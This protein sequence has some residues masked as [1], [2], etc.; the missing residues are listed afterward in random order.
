[1]INLLADERK[2]D[3]RA[4]RVNVILSRYIAI[5]LMALVFMMAV[6]FVS[7]TVLQNTMST[8]Q[9]RIDSND[10][11]AD[12]YSNTKAQVDTLSSKLADTKSTLEQEISYSKVLTTL[13]QVMPEGTVIGSFELNEASFTGSQMELKTYAKTNEGAVVIAEKLRASPLITQVSLQSTDTAQGIEGYPIGVNLTIT[14]NR[15]WAK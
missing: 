13:G 10:V 7:Y 9:T 2:N 5:I 8:A 15:A 3:I 14:L 1:M 4:A 11:K 12:I 6:L